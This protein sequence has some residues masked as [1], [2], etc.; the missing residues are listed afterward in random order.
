MNHTENFTLRISPL[1]KKMLKK[2]AKRLRRTQSDTIRLLIRSYLPA[3]P[4][5]E[6]CQGKEEVDQDYRSARRA[7]GLIAQ[8]G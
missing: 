4:K 7:T 1:E 3:L 2:L 8:K 6:I 5:H